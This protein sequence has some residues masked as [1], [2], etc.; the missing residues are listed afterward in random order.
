MPRTVSEIAA[1]V[2][3]GLSTLDVAPFAALFAADA[4]YEVPFLGQRIEGRDAVVATLTAGGVRARAAGLTKA[5]VTT[6]FTDSGLGFVVELVVSGPGVEFPSSV[7]IVTVSNG[8]I[9]AYR[10]YPDTSA[11]AKLERSSAERVVKAESPQPAE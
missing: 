8:E 11:A 2:R 5:Q 9:T 6:T 10:D 4:V 7:G 3:S 1:L